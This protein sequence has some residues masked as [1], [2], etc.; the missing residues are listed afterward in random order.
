MKSVAVEQ[1]VRCSLSNCAPLIIVCLGRVD[2]ESSSFKFDNLGRGCQRQTQPLSLGLGKKI[3]N[4]LCVRLLGLD[5]ASMFTS[6]WRW[7]SRRTVK[8]TFAYS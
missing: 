5:G 2:S 7:C 1:G 4:K 3:Y 6:P 8:Q